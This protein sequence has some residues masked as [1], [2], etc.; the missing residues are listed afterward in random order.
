MLK[1]PDDKNCD[2]YS[3]C[4]ICELFID[5]KIV[6]T[7]PQKCEMCFNKKP[8]VSYPDC[9]IHVCV[10]CLKSMMFADK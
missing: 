4:Y 5:S 8:L 9:V 3:L 6:L 2:K 7:T 1:C 10:A